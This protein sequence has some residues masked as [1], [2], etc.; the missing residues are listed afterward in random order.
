[1]LTNGFQDL[2]TKLI[3]IANVAEYELEY[4][5][6]HKTNFA[7]TSTCFNYGLY[8]NNYRSFKPSVARSEMESLHP[9]NTLQLCQNSRK[10]I[11]ITLSSLCE[12]T[13]FTEF[14]F[15][16]LRLFSIHSDKLFSKV[17]SG[18]TIKLTLI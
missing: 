14:P 15:V 13:T 10:T 11:R 6:G 18:N 17:R 8:K 4:S 9:K 1:M 5:N 12:Y 2:D 7:N 16:T 3:I